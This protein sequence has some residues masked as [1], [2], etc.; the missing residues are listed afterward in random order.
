MQHNSTTFTDDAIH[1]NLIQ[2]CLSDIIKQAIDLVNENDTLM[3]DSI[4]CP[5]NTGKTYE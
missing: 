3:I 2:D 4:T 1:P 5:N